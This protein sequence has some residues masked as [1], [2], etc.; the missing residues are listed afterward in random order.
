MHR[1]EQVWH[2]AH[3]RLQRAI[4][5]QRIQA[6][7]LRRPHPNNQPGQKVWLF[8]ISPVT[9]RLEPPANYRIS[10]SFQVS[11][12]K[13]AFLEP[14]L[15]AMTQEP[16]PPLEVEGRPAYLVKE[17]LD[18]RHRGSQMQ[19]LVDWEGYQPEERSWVATKEILDPSLIQEFH[20]S[21]LN[22]PAPP[23]RGRPSK[24]TP[25]GSVTTRDANQPATQQREPSPEY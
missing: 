21:H 25:G 13:P 23:P 20:Q 2:S 8:T 15:G 11:L 3:V 14:G 22:H 18:S 24:R 4:R 9:Y 7:R 10:P 1:C 16:P 5:A 6:D 12:L 17:I 19:H